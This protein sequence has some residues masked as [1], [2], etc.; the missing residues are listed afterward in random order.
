MK[1]DKKVLVLAAVLFTLA[2]LLLW[3]GWL[4]TCGI[5]RHERVERHGGVAWRVGRDYEQLMPVTDYSIPHMTLPMPLTIWDYV[6]PDLRRVRTTYMVLGE[7]RPS[8]ILYIVE[9]R[10]VWQSQKEK[11]ELESHLAFAAHRP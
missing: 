9:T 10:G 4:W 5:F 7:T 8:P 3:G 11:E 6:R 1:T 2:L